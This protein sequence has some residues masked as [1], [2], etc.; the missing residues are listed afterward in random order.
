[1]GVQE[2]VLLLMLLFALCSPAS[3]ALV[4][5]NLIPE[6]T[7]ENHTIFGSRGVM[8]N[9]SKYTTVLRGGGGGGRSGGDGGQS[10]TSPQGGGNGVVPVY[11]A[12]AAGYRRNHKG[13][14]TTYTRCWKGRF[15]VLI[16]TSSYLLLYPM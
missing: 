2:L 7:H 12:G 8:V 9:R 11:A 1:M 15:A 3:F 4:S 14:S 5:K 13:D 6:N 16:A 10:N